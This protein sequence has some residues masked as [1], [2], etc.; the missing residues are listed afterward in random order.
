[1]GPGEGR[2]VSFEIELESDVLLMRAEVARS[3][4]AWGATRQQAQEIAIVVSELGMNIVK[5]AAPGKVTLRL[6]PGPDARLEMVAEDH[7]PGIRDVEKA[8]RDLH[9]QEGPLVTWEG[10]TRP[11][12]E[13]L[14]CGLGAVQ[15]LTDQLEV[16]S[17]EPHGTRIRALKRLGPPPEKH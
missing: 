5:N 8:L 10:L 3:M 7:G 1:M 14:G 2:G 13:G 6:I 17:L 12:R 9:T 16:T 15:R 4:E 11:P